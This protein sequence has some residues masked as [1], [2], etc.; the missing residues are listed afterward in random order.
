MPARVSWSMFCFP[1]RLRGTTNI[2]MPSSA[3]KR[4]IQKVKVFPE[5]VLDIETTCLSPRRQARETLICQRQGSKPNTWDTLS[6]TK[7]THAE[8]NRRESI[9]TDLRF[10][11]M[12][13][14]DHM[15]GIDGVRSCA[16]TACYLTR[17][18]F[19]FFFF[20]PRPQTLAE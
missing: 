7:I 2:K 12:T 4:G 15:G 8:S 14:R 9:F 13:A 6:R 20:S 11:L 1:S 5:P 19:C 10:S 17:S 18:F 16:L 3:S